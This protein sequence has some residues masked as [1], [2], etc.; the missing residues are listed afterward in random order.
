MISLTCLHHAHTH[1]HPR[2]RSY[3]EWGVERDYL[4]SSLHSSPLQQAQ[5]QHLQTIHKKN[6]PSLASSVASS[7]ATAA[8][9]PVLD[10]VS[11]S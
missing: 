5:Q 1:T 7:S 4:P 3:N 2:T 11:V 6:R 9:V 8:V 10:R